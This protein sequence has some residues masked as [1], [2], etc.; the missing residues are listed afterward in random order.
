MIN[1]SSICNE[2]MNN[3]RVVLIAASA[4]SPQWEEMSINWLKLLLRRAKREEK[5]FSKRMKEPN[6][7]YGI[8]G[9]TAFWNAVIDARTYISWIPV[10]LK[11][12]EERKNG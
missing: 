5:Y 10:I 6:L 7:I 3:H 12:L 9:R 11:D 2:L 8:L 1:H 4:I